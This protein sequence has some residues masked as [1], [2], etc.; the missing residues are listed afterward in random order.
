MLH[1]CELNRRGE[2]RE[3]GRKQCAPCLLVL[4][5]HSCEHARAHVVAPCLD[6]ME[7][8]EEGGG[9]GGWQK[10]M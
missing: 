4:C 10:E 7:G 2:G 6:G 8:E 3:G 1:A 9:G 5:S